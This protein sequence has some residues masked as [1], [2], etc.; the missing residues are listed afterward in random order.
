MVHNVCKEF[1]SDLGLVGGSPDYWSPFNT[2]KY[3]L[4]GFPL[5]TGRK[6]DDI[7]LSPKH[8]S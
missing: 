3:S 6:G 8:D 2:M 1:A 5:E 4:Q 7:H